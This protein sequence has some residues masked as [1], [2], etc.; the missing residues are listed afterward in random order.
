[1]TTN[2]CTNPSFEVNLTGWTALPDT[3]IAQDNTWALYGSEAMLVTTEGLVTGEGFTGPVVNAGGSSTTGAVSLSFLST[4]TGTLTFEAIDSDTMVVLG[5]A[6]VTL[7][8]N[9][10]WDQRVQVDFSLA[11]SENF[12]VMVTTPMVQALSFWVD[13]CQYETG[14]MTASPYIDGDQPGCEWLGTA[15]L[16]ASEQLYVNATSASG[17]MYLDGQ[18]SPLTYD[19][20]FVTSAS[21]HMTLSGGLAPEVNAVPVAAFTDFAIFG[22]TDPDPAQTYADENN[23]G[24]LSGDGAYAQSYGIFVPPL[25]YPVSNG[26]FAW[27]R[28]VYMDVGFY[29][30]GVPSLNE[31]IITDVQ[32]S[33]IPY[34]TETPLA[35]TPPRQIATII[36]PTRLNFCINPAFAVDTSGWTGINT[37]T[38]AT[39]SSVLPTS[40]Y[41]TV[42]QVGNLLSYAN[43][44][45]ITNDGYSGLGNL[46]DFSDTYS[47]QQ[48]AAAGLGFGAQF[49]SGGVQYTMP[50]AAPGTSDNVQ[51]LGQ[52]IPV[53]GVPGASVLGVLGTSAGGSG[54]GTSATVTIT[55][56]D[57]TISTATLDISDW[58][59]GSG[60][61]PVV[62]GNYVAATMAYRNTPSGA[63]VE[64]T[65]LFTT[66]LAVDSAKTIA[67]VTLPNS[68]H[69][70]IFGMSLA[71]VSSQTYTTNSGKVTVSASGDGVE[72]SVPDL[73]VGDIYTVS[74][75]VQ[76][77]ADIASIT[78]ICGDAVPGIAGSGSDTISG[79][80]S[81][82]L[83]TGEWFPMSF[84]FVATSSSGS[85]Y[86][87]VYGNTYAG[88]AVVEITATTTTGA[89]LPTHFWLNAVLI[90]EGEVVGTYFDGSFG[91]AD[92]QDYQW[93]AGGT[94]GKARSYYY[95][96]FQVKQ[97]TVEQV[98]QQHIPL[99][100]SA[101]PPDYLIPYSQ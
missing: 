5:S 93:E 29:Y 57:G 34:G 70:H 88:P 45:G 53:A 20:S 78:A 82:A 59:L 66:N 24:M 46:D 69:L 71:T 10:A 75:L 14:V 101:P 60:A 65:Y 6:T 48:L 87:S 89:S 100:L 8:G 13:G 39:D 97:F 7:D 62:S 81:G 68:L 99:G 42:A 41:E 77:G 18:A 61:D 56:I 27:R 16:S 11:S 19:E 50:G 26:A 15:G 96:Q 1:M 35:Y 49:T 64:G 3:D 76:A 31:E 85:G 67:S 54:T 91:S 40:E 52:T 92:Y 58:T 84:S 37:G 25:D 79:P 51:C 23:A 44:T 74:F 22:L 73:I 90:E 80:D 43:S 86:P 55:Y 83:T 98:L 17:A 32:V 47:A 12:Q 4:A 21:G 36:K 9:N 38:I 28:A 95:E 63:Q 30:T 94:A 33:L 72:L 2:L